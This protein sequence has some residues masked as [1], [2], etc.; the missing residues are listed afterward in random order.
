M[1]WRREQ[2]EEHGRV[3][4]DH[5]CGEY[6][7]AEGMNEDHRRHGFRWCLLRGTEELGFYRT[8]GAAKADAAIDSK[9]VA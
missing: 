9:A 3:W 5:V 2:T 1:R 7:I 8:V 4:L 6:R